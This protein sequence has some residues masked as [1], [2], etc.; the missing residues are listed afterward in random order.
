MNIT[1]DLIIK[2]IANVDSVL[3]YY[4]DELVDFNTHLQIQ[5][6]RIDTAVIEQAGW[7]SFYDTKRAE[8]KIIY[9]YM[10]LK[11]ATIHSIKWQKFTEKHDRALTQKDKEVYIKHDVDY[12]NMSILVLHTKEVYEQ[13]MS[14][15]DSFKMRGYSLNNLT[16]L[17]TTNQ[18][19]W[20]I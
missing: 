17:K 4:R 9:E 7:Y 18:E 16:K 14:I 3:Q 5:Y 10:E 15:V 11:L 12:I 13:Y 1:L 8:L 19:D 2:D 20:V 6:K